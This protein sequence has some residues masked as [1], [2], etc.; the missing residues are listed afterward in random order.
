MGLDHGKS[1]AWWGRLVHYVFMGCIRPNPQNSNVPFFPCY[2]YIWFVPRQIC[3]EK[4]MNWKGWVGTWGI[5]KKLKKNIDPVT[6]THLSNTYWRLVFFYCDVAIIVKKSAKVFIEH[7]ERK[8]F[9][10][11]IWIEILVCSYPVTL[12]LAEP[13]LHRHLKRDLT[14]SATLT[15][16]VIIIITRKVRG[17]AACAKCMCPWLWKYLVFGC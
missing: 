8:H 2:C 5:S 16:Y 14:P 13:L 7:G 15:R 4:F 6:R 9:C 10:N 17:V 1:G 12:I 3:P 11:V